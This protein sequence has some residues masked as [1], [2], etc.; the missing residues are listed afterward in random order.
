LVACDIHPLNIVRVLKF[1][2]QVL[3]IDAEDR[4][5][6]Y[7]HWVA[8]GLAAAESLLNRHRRGANIP[9][10]P[11]RLLHSSLVT[12]HYKHPPLRVV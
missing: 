6:R 5:R 10:P 3:G 4:Q 12:V 9:G 7:A 8:E 2:S 1:L 11:P